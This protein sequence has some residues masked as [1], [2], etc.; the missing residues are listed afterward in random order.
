MCVCVCVC[1]V[2]QSCLALCGPI[3]Y[4]EQ[5]PLSMEFSQQEY[6]SVL[7]FP[8]PE[9]LPDPGIKLASPVSPALVDGFLTSGS[10]WEAQ[11]K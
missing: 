4:S 7:P 8:S 2:A 9:D 5:A 11:I 1:S 6:R 10:T 3:V